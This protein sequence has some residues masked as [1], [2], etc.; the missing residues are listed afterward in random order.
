MI[1]ALLVALSVCMLLALAVSLLSN[2]GIWRQW[3][4]SFSLTLLSGIGLFVATG[5]AASPSAKRETSDAFSDLGRAVRGF[6]L[7][8][9]PDGSGIVGSLFRVLGL[10]TQF[11]EPADD[12][13]R[14]EGFAAVSI[15]WVAMAVFGAVPFLLSGSIPSITDAFFETMSGFTTTGASILTDIEAL[16]PSILFWRSLTH[17][18]GGMGIIVLS[19]AI[20][21]F[22][23][24]GGMQLFRAE[25]PGPAP[26]RLQPRIKETAKLLWGVYVA[27]TVLEIISL[28]IAGMPL[29]DSC[30]HAFGTLGTGGFSTKNGSIG[31]Y[32]SAAIDWIIIVFML[33]AG[34]NF[35][36]HFM[37]FRNK[38]I[39]GYLADLEFRVYA[40]IAIVSVATIFGIVHFGGAGATTT[41]ATFRSVAFT[42]V[43]LGTSTGYATVDYAQWA[44]LT[45]ALL[46]ILMFVGG[47]AGSTG[48]GF[49]MVRAV[50]LVR[51]TRIELRRLLHPRAVIS[52]KYSNRRVPEAII[53]NVLGFFL[54]YMIFLGLGAVCL[55]LVDIDLIT[56]GTASLACLSN[57]GPGLGEVGPT[58]NYAW[59][60]DA[61]KW[62]LAGWMLLGRLEI[63]TVLI[64]FAPELWRR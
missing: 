13:R 17:W 61:A 51:F 9:G 7:R 43:S 57:I 25:V 62:L 10:V 8:E 50:L 48:G 6:Q 39:S 49:K 30:C 2:D 22:L 12:L 64:F 20:L 11:T 44:V 5:S 37:A 38:S 1:G 63:Y 52:V 15:G 45:H 47:C 58:A 54:L 55:T 29:L 33:F 24:V 42:V 36:L 18:I 28:T 27:L 32:D 16:N 40:L 26:D 35:T 46:L 4:S 59:M 53:Q 60:P 56:A 19:L 21:P 31:A 23:G 41:E 14:S 34:S 3:I